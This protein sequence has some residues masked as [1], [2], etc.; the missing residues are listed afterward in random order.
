MGCY[1][2]LSYKLLALRANTHYW[3]GVLGKDTIKVKNV[4]ADLRKGVISVGD[5]SALFVGFKGVEFYS[6]NES[7]MYQLSYNI[8]TLEFWQIDIFRSLSDEEGKAYIDSLT[9]NE[10]PQHCVRLKLTQKPYNPNYRPSRYEY[11]LLEKIGY[12]LPSN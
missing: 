7:S 11:K 9:K 3:E 4:V 2:P 1:T 8:D 10:S 5:S 12:P 6:N